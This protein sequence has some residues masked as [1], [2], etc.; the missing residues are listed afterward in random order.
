MERMTVIESYGD[1][2]VSRAYARMAGGYDR[3]MAIFERMLF[4][5]F[6]GWAT[7]QARG[8][9]LELGVGTGLNL[10]HYGDDVRVVGVDLSDEMLDI[11]RRRADQLRLGQRVELRQGNVQAL[12]VPDGSFDTVLS[13]FTFCTIPDPAAAAREA[14]RVLRPGGRFVVAEHGESTM[15]WLTATLRGIERIAYRFD[16]DHLAR[17]PVRYVQEAGFEVQQ[18]HRSKA[19]IAFRIL[20]T[21]AA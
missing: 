2:A 16:A 21:K 12:D 4:R 6:R 5:G 10:P 19:G 9:V 15:R 14:W 18:V 3:Q 20:A 1:R 11:A 7:G 13:T 8:A 17:N